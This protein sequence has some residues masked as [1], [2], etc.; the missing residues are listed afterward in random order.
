MTITLLEAL[1]ALTIDHLKPL[2]AFT[3]N[4]PKVIRKAELVNALHDALL[5]EGLPALWKTLGARQRAA[6]AEALYDPQGRYDAIRFAAKYGRTSSLGNDDSHYSYRNKTTRLGLFI[7]CLGGSDDRGVPS[8]LRTRLLTFVPPPAPLKLKTY[9]EPF[10]VAEQTLRLT[11]RDALQELAVMLRTIER[12]RVQVSEKTALPSA[13]AMRLLAGKLSRGDYYPVEEAPPP[14][15][16]TIGPIKAFAW[17]MLLQAGGLAVR[18]GSRLALSPAGIKALSAPPA[19]VLRTLW[20]K[21]QKTTLLD[22]FSRV[23]AIKGQASTGRVMS[24]VAP[25]RAQIEAALKVA[26]ND[27]PQGEWMAL[28]EFSNFMLAQGLQ[29]VVAHDPWKLYLVDRNYGSLGYDGANG[30]NILQ[31]R[32]I[33][34]V[35]F[36]YAATL[37]LIDVAYIDPTQ[38]LYDTDFSQMWGADELD[39]LSRYDGLMS[40]RITTLGAY[41]LGMTDSYTPTIA[42][43]DAALS[44]LPSLRVNVTRGTLSAE[45]VFL[46]ETWAQPV[47]AG[48]WLLDAQKA[49]TAI[50]KGHPIAEL[51]RFLEQYDDLPLPE[52]VEAFIIRC[53]RDAS[54]LKLGDSA[55]L[56]ECRDAATAQRIAAHPETQPLCLLAGASTLVVRADQVDKFRAAVH[57]LGLGLVG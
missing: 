24:A 44:V 48:S 6:V 25:R 20:H 57:L 5:G 56:V 1:T 2:L 8:D 31:E 26:F 52:P 46:L 28:G 10:E 30:W 45:A 33:R 40:F 19:E 14:Y 43:S 21:W 7:H 16:C 39:F 22:E 47:H 15:E 41:V 27:C 34:T 9:P 35:L 51:Q 13:A 54:A 3:P 12:E 32:Y 17:P 55:V 11:E 23:D 50:E 4:A 49:L 53:G 37:G 42:P 36:E 18:S 29:F 38:T